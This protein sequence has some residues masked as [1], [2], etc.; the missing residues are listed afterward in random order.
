MMKTVFVLFS[1]FLVS[2]HGQAQPQTKVDSIFAAIHTAAVTMSDSHREGLAIPEVDRILFEQQGAMIAS[3][4][5]GQHQ[6]DHD[7]Q[8]FMTRWMTQDSLHRKELVGLVPELLARGTPQEL[9]GASTILS[10][11]RKDTTELRN[12]YLLASRATSLGDSSAD[13]LS[14]L[15]LSYYISNHGARVNGDSIRNYWAKAYPP[16]AAS[17]AMS[18]NWLPSYSA[19]QAEAKRTKQNIFIDFTGYTV[20][21]CRFMEQTIFSRDDVKDLLKNF[22]LVRLYTDNGTPDNDANAKMEESRF[23]TIGLPYYVIISPEDKLLATFPGFTRDV[24]AF[25]SFLSL[26]PSKVARKKKG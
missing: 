25:K 24:E 6:N 10:Q 5:F 11:H 14:V 16:P 7:F 1:M 13:H 20:T 9:K 23:N 22:V 15:A 26:K 21:N 3:S 8:A 2:C 12:A 4:A 18:L 19:A 17:G